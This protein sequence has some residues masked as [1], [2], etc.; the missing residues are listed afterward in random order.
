MGK[1]WGLSLRFETRK[2]STTSKMWENLVD[3]GSPVLYS[4]YISFS[5][6]WA[7]LLSNTNDQLLFSQA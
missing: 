2:F 7:T 3:A 5:L 4:T 6:R 1:G